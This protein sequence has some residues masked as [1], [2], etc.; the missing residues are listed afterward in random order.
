MLNLDYDANLQQ[1]LT[2]AHNL[3]L[4]KCNPH[5]LELIA[6]YILYE[7]S[8][9][10]K[11]KSKFAKSKSTP[12]ANIE[13]IEA[14]PTSKFTKPKPELHKENPY[15]QQY[16]TTIDWLRDIIASTPQHPELWK[17]KQWKIIHSMDMGIANSL[18]YPKMELR[19]TFTSTAPIDIDE[20]IDLTN[21]F[22]I[23]KLI[24]NYS[25]LRQSE[26]SKLWIEW[27]EKNIIDKTPMYDWQRHLLIRRIDKMRQVSI[28]VELAEKFGKIVTPSTMSQTMRTLYR[29]IAITAEKEL[30]AY[31]MRN[32]KP[33]WRYCPHCGEW[34]LRE[35]DFYKSKT[36]CKQCL[37]E[38]SAANGKSK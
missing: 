14:Q 1:R 26:H 27:V 12:H 4:T 15:I 31:H 7:D 8:K 33:A 19:P 30:Y 10:N 13:E 28:A 2:I 5:E 35:F 25:L 6:N 20:H 11:P 9:S 34:K 18:L 21:S 23:S 17:L 3:P 16:E 37:K 22:H 38:R 36:M 29:Q 32:Y 24:D